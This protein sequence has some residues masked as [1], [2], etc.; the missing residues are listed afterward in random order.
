MLKQKRNAD[1][2]SYFAHI[3][4]THM[5]RCVRDGY[6]NCYFISSSGIGAMMS[7]RYNKPCFYKM[8]PA[9]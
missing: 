2:T 3:E 6:E 5:R 9:A 8:P 1:S 4:K 7:K